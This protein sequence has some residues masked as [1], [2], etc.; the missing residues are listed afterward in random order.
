M[1][2]INSRQ[3]F[4][5]F[6]SGYLSVMNRKMKIAV[7]GCGSRGQIYCTLAARYKDRIE[8]VAAADPSP[9][10]L[11]RISQIVSNPAV[12]LFDSS[13]S[14]L[15]VPR[16]A[17]V[18]M[19]CTQDDY[20]FIPCKSAIE[21]G[22]DILIE[23]PVAQSIGEVAEISRL[24]EQHGRKIMVCYVLLYAILP[25]GEGVAGLRHSGRYRNVECQ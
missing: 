5:F 12:R 25:E 24:A 17:D 1:K 19:I 18:M 11:E 4:Q 2:N 3:D 8:V 21:K 14:L 15:S 16:L 20:H 22:Y 23:K 13:E 9:E 10:K 7:A 6:A